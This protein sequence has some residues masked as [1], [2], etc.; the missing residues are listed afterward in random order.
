[1]NS[2]DKELIRAARRDPDEF[3]KLYKKYKNSKADGATIA[4]KMSYYAKLD[5]NGDYSG[6]GSGTGGSGDDGGNKPGIVAKG[7]DF[8]KGL[9]NTQKVQ[10]TGYDDKEFTRINDV[11]D[12]LNEKGEKVGGIKSI[13]GRALSNI[14][15]GIATQ[16]EQE[17]TLRTEINEQVGLQGELSRGVR[18]EMM[19]AYPS[20]L[21]LGYGIGQLTAMM[22]NL[23]NESGRFNMISQET[24]Q[25]SA[26]IAR[27]FV[28]DLSDM[29]KVFNEFERVGIGA[30][31][32]M[33]GIEKA[34]VNSLSLGLNS[35]KTTEL[36]RT[37]LGKLNE[38]GFAN[39][40][41]GLN[42]MVQKSLEFRMSMSEVFKI[43]DKVFSPESALELSANLQ[44]LGG[45]IG[46][47]N[48]PLKLMYM[49]TNNVEG[50]QDALI[51]AA[52]SLATYNQEQGRFEITGVNLR[53]AKAM[54]QELGISY[55]ELAKGAIA[56]AERSSA[57][58]AL[59][60][61]GLVMKDDEK[62][63]LTNLS[64]MKDGKM[65]IEVPKTLSDEFKGATEVALEDLTEAQKTTLLRNKEAFEK[66]SAE[67]IARG[68]LNATENIQRDVA[69][70][71]A[72][73][74]GQ[75][76]NAVKNAAKAA[77]F[78]D[79]DVAEKVKT[80]TDSVVNGSLNGMQEINAWVT[81]NI[82]KIKGGGDT[83]QKGTA[84]GKTQSVS[85][86]EANKKAE[87]AKSSGEK[88][89]TIRYEYDFKGGE[90]VTDGIRRQIV[91]DAS[92]KDDFIYQDSD[93]YIVPPK[94]K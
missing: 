4:S 2:Q 16:L 81:E 87:A 36:L 51:G 78:S 71:A 92:I 32:A 15:E 12:I 48:D 64:R 90:A 30:K 58:S 38:F 8:L 74:R 73:A 77:G 57:A 1:M 85:V 56:S 17:A 42:R 24:I 21:R 50:L 43:A 35:K 49:A 13:L 59:M 53:K 28:G 25:E 26:K 9:L 62:E 19:A 10:T 6:G 23:M 68:Q 91:K 80:M 40:V 7:N 88:V 5:E 22:T 27:A 20:T 18:E 45:A 86:E 39:G 52:G 72:T 79:E 67:D 94:S 44:V 47:F 93:E 31:D 84:D 34:G 82:K 37:D 65:V 33:I 54:A 41:Q 11:L 66:M 63:F 69:F 60:M 76:V 29:G 83:K 61:N 3:E 14:G 46:D 55:D 89:T 70:M 75:A